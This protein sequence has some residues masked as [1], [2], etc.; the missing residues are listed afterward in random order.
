MGEIVVR[1]IRLPLRPAVLVELT[2]T[3]AGRTG[4]VADRAVLT[5]PAAQMS[6]SLDH[7]EPEQVA[8]IAY[9]LAGTAEQIRGRYSAPGASPTDV[10]TAAQLA[11]VAMMV[12]RA[13]G[14][15]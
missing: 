4:D 5:T 1:G 12:R 13:Y 9:H 14:L 10:E 8:R 7:L 15:G 2:E 11:A 3:V 6:L